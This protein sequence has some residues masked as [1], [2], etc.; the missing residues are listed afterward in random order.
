MTHCLETEAITGNE[1][2]SY[3]PGVRPTLLAVIHRKEF[4]M[5][6]S[7]F[8]SSS[9]AAALAFVAVG[10]VTAQ[11]AAAYQCKHLSVRSNSSATHHKAVSKSW[12]RNNAVHGWSRRAKSR[13]GQVWSVWSIAKNAS[14]SCNKNGSIWRCKAKGKPCKYV[15]Y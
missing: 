8:I 11:P 7:N 1:A 3:L 6:K 14:V 10:I 9:A 12:A 2:F 15:V 13:F 5:L 4:N